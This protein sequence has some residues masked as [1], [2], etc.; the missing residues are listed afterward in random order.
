MWVHSLVTMYVSYLLNLHQI[1][2]KQ[3]IQDMSFQIV[4]S[5]LFKINVIWFAHDYKTLTNRQKQQW[6]WEC[7]LQEHSHQFG[8]MSQAVINIKLKEDQ[9]L[10]EKWKKS[11]GKKTTARNRLLDLYLHVSGEKCVSHLFLILA[12]HS[13]GR[14]FFWTPPGIFRHSQ[15][16][17]VPMLT[18]LCW[19]FLLELR[20]RT[21]TLSVCFKNCSS[22]LS[23]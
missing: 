9:E 18:M 20:T 23:L 17:M 21:K 6:L 16:T 7:Y 1:M 8:D 22:T 15:L 2:H 3:V 14:W 10:L 13:M 11:K 4:S 12:Y 19:L 5:I